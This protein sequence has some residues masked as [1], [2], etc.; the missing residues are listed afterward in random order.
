MSIVSNRF[1]LVFLAIAVILA[2]I[3]TPLYRDAARDAQAG[4]Y[5][6]RSN[7][8]LITGITVRNNIPEWGGTLTT[9]LGWHMDCQPKGDN[10]NVSLKPRDNI[11]WALHFTTAV[12]CP[13]NNRD[14]SGLRAMVEDL[15]EQLEKHPQ[16]PVWDIS[17][18][19]FLR[20]LLMLLPK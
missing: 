14:A 11:T 15:I 18:M 20:G 5:A 1:F 12:P 19:D 3:A 16:N 4:V 7:P 10:Y 13:K 9:A 6:F 17:G 8:V 2:F